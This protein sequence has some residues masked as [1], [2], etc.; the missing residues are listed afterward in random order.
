[1]SG[2]WH[3]LVIFSSDECDLGG[4][5]H[6][7]ATTGVEKLDVTPGV[8]RIARG[9]IPNP[10][11]LRTEQNTRYP[12]APS[13]GWLVNGGRTAKSQRVVAGKR[14]GEAAGRNSDPQ[15]T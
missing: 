11:A 6:I 7:V 4:F 1:M 2:E 9:R 12:K 3:S 8:V 5:D 13:M 15:T 10:Y 14:T